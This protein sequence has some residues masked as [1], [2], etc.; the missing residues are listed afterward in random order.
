MLSTRLYHRGSESFMDHASME[1]DRV[2]SIPSGYSRE[3]QSHQQGQVEGHMLIPSR[4]LMVRGGLSRE[5]CK[6]DSVP[7][8]LPLFPSTTHSMA[9]TSLKPKTPLSPLINLHVRLTLA[10]SLGTLQYCH[11][12]FTS[13]I[14][15]IGRPNHNRTNILLGWKAV[16]LKRLLVVWLLQWNRGIRG[17]QV[18]T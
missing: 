12:S 7:L 14:G 3:G 18:K 2:H 4:V 6:F 13:C 1:G 8:L 16:C 10:Q 5:Q 9:Y 11:S 17:G 15:P